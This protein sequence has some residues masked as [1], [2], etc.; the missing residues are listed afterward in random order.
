M[1]RRSRR[2]APAVIVALA[3]LAG[4]IAVAVSL[5]Q[6]LSD[7]RE[8][9][10]YTALATRLHDT[11]WSAG[12]VLVAGIAALV[13]GAVLLAAALWPGR[14]VVVPLDAE[15]GVRAGI[16]RRS[17]RGAVHDAVRSVDGVDSARVRLGRKRIRVKGR[18]ADA[19]P[20]TVRAAVAERLG[21]I[22]P[23]VPPRIETA[24]RPARTG[25]RR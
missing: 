5:I 10:S 11:T 15:D 7:H 20:E 4:S 21:T 22:A 23:R 8:F 16:A 1:T 12:P 25:G 2:I 19:A 3:L 14:S 24:L 9:V 18:G 13:V 17:L 6:K